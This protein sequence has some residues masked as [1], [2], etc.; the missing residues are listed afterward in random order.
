MTDRPS[1]TFSIAESQIDEKVAFLSRPTA[2]AEQPTYVEVRET[3]MSWVFLTENLAYKLK[4]PVR[5]DYLDFSTLEARRDDCEREV[6][7]NRRLTEDVYLGV[8]AL[9]VDHSDNMR[10]GHDGRIVDWLVK[11]RR[12]PADRML[13][14]MICEKSVEVRSVDQLGSL[15]SDFYQH[16]QPVGM[17]A[18]QYVR[19]FA[20]DIEANA[21]EL[22]RSEFSLAADLVQRV[23]QAQ[24]HFTDEHRDTLA[25]RAADERIVEA[26]GDMRPEHICLTESKPAIIDCLEFNREFRLLDPVDEL[27]FFS[28]ECDLL[29]AGWIGERVL[30]SYMNDAD[31]RVLPELVHFYTAYRATLRA[32]IAA[33]HTL[34]HHV[35]QTP[36]WMNRATHY[37]EKAARLLPA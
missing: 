26:H 13:D 30:E 23:S 9:S 14:H 32:K 1:T 28:L 24:L 11:M 34:D 12:L 15:L 16:L 18:E 25:S 7:L 37:L 21:R 33:W 19:R 8:E 31:D 17:T 3:H 35:E 29:G 5:Y 22:S 10:I 36:K 6:R 4:K 27:C 2:Y 20:R